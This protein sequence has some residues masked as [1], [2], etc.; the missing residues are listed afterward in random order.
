MTMKYQRK[1]TIMIEKVGIKEQDDVM[2][3]DQNGGSIYVVNWSAGYLLQLLESPLGTEELGEI[4]SSEFQ[5][6]KEQLKEQLAQMIEIFN[7]NGW[8]DVIET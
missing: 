8:V 2:V 4:V 1:S 7:R 5:A 6:D 3:Q